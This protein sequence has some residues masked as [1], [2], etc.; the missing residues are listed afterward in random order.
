VR[1]IPK[2]REKDMI[3]I[4]ETGDNDFVWD[5]CSGVLPV[6]VRSVDFVCHVDNAATRHRLHDSKAATVANF[7]FAW[8]S[9]MIPLQSYTRSGLHLLFLFFVEG[10]MF[11]QI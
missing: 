6:F 8:L 7:C 9:A 2:E 5:G 3:W 10:G 11:M 1:L 4:C